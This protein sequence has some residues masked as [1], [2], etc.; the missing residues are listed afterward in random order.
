MRTSRPMSMRELT[1]KK[2]E[3]IC[4]SIEEGILPCVYGVHKN[5]N[6]DSMLKTI[7]EKYPK[8]SIAVTALEFGYKLVINEDA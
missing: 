6:L 5:T 2:I 7:L 1:Q 3:D 4:S 8:I